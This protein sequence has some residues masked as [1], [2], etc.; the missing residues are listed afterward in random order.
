M[1]SGRTNRHAD[2]QMSE[3]IE[4]RLGHAL[5]EFSCYSRPTRAVL[6]KLRAAAAKGAA[7]SLKGSRELLQFFTFFSFFHNFISSR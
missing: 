4:K 3:F 7:A 1:K 2:I 6:P 5:Y